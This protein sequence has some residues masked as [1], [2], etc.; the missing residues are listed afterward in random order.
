LAILVETS[1]EMSKTQASFYE[2][3]NKDTQTKTVDLLI[4]GAIPELDMDTWEIKNRADK[5]VRDFLK[6]EKEFDRINIRINSPGGS[7]YHAFPIY[8]VIAN[9]KK[10]VHTYNDGLAAS[11]GGVLLLAGKTIHAAKNAF[12]MI[13]RASGLAMGDAT[14]M[15]DYADMLEKYEGVI[16]DRFAEKT[17]MDKAEFISQYFDGKDHFLTAEE[18]LESGFIDTIEEYESE[19]APPANIQNMAFNE[20]MNL[21]RSEEKKEP[22][23][24]EKLTGYLRNTFQEK[25]PAAI[26]TTP[27]PTPTDM[28]FE[29]SLNLLSKESL[30]AEDLAAIKAEI[31]AY[32]S[33]GEKF[34]QEEVTAK[35]AAATE[36]LQAEITALA[37]EKANAETLLTSVNAE[38]E[39]LSTENGTLKTQ[40]SSLQLT[41]EAYRKSGVKPDNTAG[42]KPDLKDEEEEEEVIS[43]TDAAVRKMRAEMG[44][45]T[46]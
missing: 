46:K 7:L 4:Y 21:Y 38:K 24:F 39:T 30:T 44:I 2:I 42:E 17:G 29:N 11:A 15:R 45:T 6:L 1:A 34:T 43:E 12:L 9:S 27:T 26:T 32:R 22:S 19:D 25:T 20:I 14:Y 28:N 13:H 23:F 36:P 18:A 40:N 41:I 31:S 33:A 35:V 37:T 8:N 3:L 5:F 16:A 10:E